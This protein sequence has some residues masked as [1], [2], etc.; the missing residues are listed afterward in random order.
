VRTWV[1]V[2]QDKELLG[3]PDVGIGFEETEEAARDLGR[4]L[5]DLL[6][7]AGRG[8]CVFRVRDV[9]TG[10]GYRATAILRPRVQDP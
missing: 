6:A 8:R 9:E 4:R 2:V 1:V 10:R 7:E 5:V 3:E